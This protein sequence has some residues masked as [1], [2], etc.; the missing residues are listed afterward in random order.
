MQMPEARMI[1]LGNPAVGTPCCRW[2]R[3]SLH[4]PA[5][6][7]VRATPAGREVLLHDPHLLAAR[8]GLKAEQVGGLAGFSRMVEDVL[9]G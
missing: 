1:V 7:R 4:L 8:Y 9:K 2:L 5:R 6:V 3:L